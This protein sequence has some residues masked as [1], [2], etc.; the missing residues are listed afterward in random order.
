MEAMKVEQTIAARADGTVDEMLCAPGN[1][2][3][4]EAESLQQVNARAGAH[5]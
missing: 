5:T 4:E 1:Q 2:A 3:A